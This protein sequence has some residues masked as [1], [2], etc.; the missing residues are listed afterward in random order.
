MPQTLR[1]RFPGHNGL[2]L[3]GRLEMPDSTPLCYATFSH[4]F[5]CSKD[6]IST[7]RISKQLAAQG[8]AVL[9]FDFAGLGGSEGDFADT[10]FST[11]MQDLQAAADYLSQ[12]HQ[13]PKV[14]IG[15]S[16]GGTAALACAAAIDSVQAVATIA[17]PSQPRHVLHHFGEALAALEAG[18]TASIVVAGVHYKIRPRFIQDL[19]R[20]DMQQSL[21]QLDKAVLII[22]VDGDD[23][24]GASDGTD[25]RQWCAGE[26]HLLTLYGTNHILSDKEAANAAANTIAE[27]IEPYCRN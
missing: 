16:L 15:H 23:I 9:R 1:I 26:C 11:S 18:H 2:I 4:C 24:V 10:S 6:L 19:K 17:A 27:F 14:L 22:E 25:I 5:T 20:H 7:F 12:H 8:I 21:A 3:D 13:S